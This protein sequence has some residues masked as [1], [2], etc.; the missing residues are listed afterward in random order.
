MGWSVQGLACVL[1]VEQIIYELQMLLSE[2]ALSY[3]EWLQE[4]AWDMYDH[5]D[6][7]VSE[8]SAVTPTDMQ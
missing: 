1:H 7:S 6:H 4:F 3:H 8:S 2:E 5:Y